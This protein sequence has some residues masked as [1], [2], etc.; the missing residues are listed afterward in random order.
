MNE[1]NM[2][3]LTLNR[4]CNLRCKWCYA[5]GEK[6]DFNLKM[7]FGLAQE[8]IDF[9]NDLGVKEVALIGGEPTC[10]SEL[11]KLISYIKS[12]DIKV[13][14][15]T[16]GLIFSDKS[17]L[18]ELENL[19]VDSVNFSMKGWSKESYIV[20]TG[21]DAFDKTLEALKNI[22]NSNINSM[23]SFVISYENI[24]YLL[25][26]VEI[27]SECGIKNFYFSFENDFSVLD[28]EIKK[29]DVNEISK[30]VKVF[31]EN[32]EE[33]NRLTRENFTLHQSLPLCVWNK[34]II[35]KMRNKTQIQTSCILLQRSGLVFDT[36]GFLIPCNSIHQVKLG[37]FKKD[38]KDKK[39][40]YSFWNSNQM[41]KIYNKFCSLPSKTCNKC[42]DESVCGGGCLS[43]W[44]NY[45]FNDLLNENI[46]K[47]N[48][49]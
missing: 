17:Y 26:V 8:L 2:V 13:C 9:I 32:Y 10:Y 14:L 20:N 27:T 16:N 1:I 36:N 21:V 12:K 38:F 40:F 25:K 6:F 4:N 49:N 33:L 39:T 46:I 30:I 31:S 22:S 11:K 15:I 7:D 19:G 3:W 37:K 18:Q 44:Y 43:N 5:K 47:N 48:V 23:V 34:D 35:E 28:G 29:Y 24:D 45:E 42:K 41:N